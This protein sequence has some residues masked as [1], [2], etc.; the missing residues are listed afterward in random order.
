M[1][2]APPVAPVSSLRLN[3]YLNKHIF[4]VKVC[5][6]ANNQFPVPTPGPINDFYWNIKINGVIIFNEYF[7]T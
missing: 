5:L 6:Q 3:Q 4:V 2:F 1:K 7:F